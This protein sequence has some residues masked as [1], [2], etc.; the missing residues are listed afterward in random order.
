MKTRICIGC[1]K[2]KPA[3]AEYFTRHAQSRGG[4]LAQCKT[5]KH[6]EEKARRSANID[7]ARARGRAQYKKH[8]KG[9]SAARKAAYAANPEPAKARAK[10][11]RERNPEYQPQYQR[12]YREENRPDLQNYYREWLSRGDNEEKGRERTRRWF[13]DN[14]ERARALAHT[15]R[16]RKR[17]VPGSHTAEDVL[18]IYRR[19]RG[20]CFYCRV[21]L[22]G[23]YHVDHKIPLSRTELN[24]T[25]GPEN[26]CC[27][28]P[29]CNMQKRD[30]TAGEF[31]KFLSESKRAFA[32]R[33]L[34]VA[35]ARG[36][37]G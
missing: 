28:C 27:A 19:Q 9:I 7:V 16:A 18:R 24:P 32:A 29:K 22:H 12:Q 15:K 14:P 5:C 20:L 26:I 30:M 31:R 4:L 25:N 37:A 6:A 8:K 36:C 35:K 11:S 33:G 23:T 21:P 17:A 2:R 34:H 1:D 3:T 10:T 13:Q